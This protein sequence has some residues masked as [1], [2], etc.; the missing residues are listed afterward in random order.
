MIIRDML[1]STLSGIR[2][3]HKLGSKS[4]RIDAVKGVSSKNIVTNTSSIKGFASPACY[5]PALS[6][7][8]A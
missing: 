6:F 2:A 8:M 3:P 1:G 5:N 4:A 7:I